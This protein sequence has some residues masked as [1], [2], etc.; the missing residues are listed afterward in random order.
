MEYLLIDLL[1]VIV[2]FIFTFHKKLRFD[3]K[4]TS[5]AL[6]LVFVAVPFVVWDVIFTNKAV[7]GFNSG[8]L[9]GYDFF[10][11]PLEEL[12]FF[13]CIPYASLFTYHCFSI[14]WKEKSFKKL[15]RYG[16]YF[17]MVLSFCVGIL[18]YDKLYTFYT[19]LFLFLALL[20]LKVLLDAK[21][22]GKFIAVYGVLL[23][24]FSV[25]NG[26]LTGSLLPSPI[27][28]YNDA[29]NL[30]VRIGTIPV[31]DI[32]YGFLLILLF[33]FIYEKNSRGTKIS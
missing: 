1:A 27:V 23:I 9:L 10:L 2:P 8:Y 5:F 21:W 6:G 4:G 13:V 22:I 25:V 19:A 20:V 7:W 33:V 15:N 31:E 14:F 29:H 32:F 16:P 3:K 24:P 11:L 12:L 17:L 18:N 26:I 28:W 30:G